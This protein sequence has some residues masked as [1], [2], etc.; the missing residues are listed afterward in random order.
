VS[1][2]VSREHIVQGT[3]AQS[4]AQTRRVAAERGTLEERSRERIVQG[5]Q[6]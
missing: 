3:R 1:R 2:A 5:T 6:A 4:A